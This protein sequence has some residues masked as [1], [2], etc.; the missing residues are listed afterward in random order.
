MPLED[1]EEELAKLKLEKEHSNFFT[2][3]IEIANAIKSMPKILWQLALV[4]L[5]QWYA[6]F[7]YWQFLTPML[8]KTIFG[9]TE[10]DE[11]KSSKILDLAQKGSNVLSTDLSWARQISELVQKAVGQTGLMNGTYNIVTMITALMLV[12]LA[13]KFSTKK[14][15]VA[16]LFGTAIALFMLPF[17]KNEFFILFPMILFGIGWAA[18]MGLPYSMVSPDIPSEKRGVYMG[19]I[20]MMIV[21]P[22][23]LQ[24]ISFGF[25]YKNLLG[26]NPVNAIILAGI[27]F[28]LASISVS[29]MKVKKINGHSEL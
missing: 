8:K 24:T 6:L 15:H 25:I 29:F 16:A 18:I 21:I 22:M 11:I 12:P 14:V 26:S 23:L 9:L 17:I 4:Y 1:S 5:F 27:L 10:A 3:F 2:P 20:N 19:I 7:I 13:M 28:V